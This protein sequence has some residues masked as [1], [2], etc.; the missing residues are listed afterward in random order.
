[1]HEPLLD[2]SYLKHYYSTVAV[3]VVTVAAAAAAVCD[4]PY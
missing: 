1:M 4:S 2:A 3:D